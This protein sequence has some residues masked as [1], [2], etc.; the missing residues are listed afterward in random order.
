MSVDFVGF[1]G[2]LVDNRRIMCYNQIKHM[3]EKLREEKN[4]KKLITAVCTALTVTAAISTPALSAKDYTTSDLL[5]LNSAI[6]GNAPMKEE[7]DVNN[8][9]IIN[10]FDLAAMRA[11]FNHTGTFAEASCYA[12]KENVKLTGRN[13]CKDNITWL[14]HSGSAAEFTVNAKSAEITINGD[15]S[16]NNGKDFAPRYAVIVD[17]EIILNET[18]TEKQKT[19]ELFSGSESRS[20]KVKVIHLS[21][22]NNGPVGVS[23]IKTVSDVSKPVMPVPEKDLRIEFIGDSITCAYGV[24]GT[25]AYENFKTSTE[26]F[27]KSYAYLTAQKLDAEY[28]SV[29]YSG[30]GIV[31]GYTGDGK[32]NTDSLVP[33]CYEQYSKNC[34]EKWDF[35]S[36]PNDV[37]VINLGTND[38]S[39]AKTEDA[40]AE[41]G[42]EY[43]EFLKKVRKCNPDAY[44][45]C[46][47]GTMGGTELY[48]YIEKAVESFKSE[49]GDKRVSCFPVPTQDSAND[50]IGSDWHPSAIT[51]QKL[52]YVV[53]D[54]ICNAIGIESDQ[55]GLDVA[56]DAE[57]SIV[58][59]DGANAATY[60]SDFDRSYWVNVVTGGT[61]IESIE[62]VASGIGLK[63]DGEY[64]LTFKCTASAGS[65]YPVIIRSSDS[66]KVYFS[67]TFKANG[68]KTPFEAEFTA[69][70]TDS[71]AEFV[72]QMGGTDYSS[73]TIYSLRLEK[74]G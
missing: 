19:V 56:A 24:E 7:Q 49:T 51:Q 12:S 46:T 37:V 50:G 18:L 52:A 48:P 53:A 58:Q 36:A 61:S 2:F 40:M 10:S 72:I 68:D 69:P 5:E 60:F 15:N 64:K 43:A 59:N 22:A 39:Y 17:D 11:T 20:A 33:P 45:L 47:L 38:S 26:N 1:L 74:I 62:A 21:E 73:A 67:G 29:S 6:L 42:E 4:M 3:S 54:K 23:E 25:S 55:I 34:T 41:Y 35:E 65:E 14:L 27:M 66:K 30:Y 32:K 16:I 70:E 31:S 9:G 8:D 71:A 44:I 57:Y 13:L 28:S 63:K